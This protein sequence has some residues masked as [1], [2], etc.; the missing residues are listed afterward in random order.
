M[1]TERVAV[2]GAR[3]ETR[4]SQE[5][6]GLRVGVADNTRDGTAGTVSKTRVGHEQC[7]MLTM[8]L[9]KVCTR[10]ETRSG[11]ERRGCLSGRRV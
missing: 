8:F 2:T 11:Q 1:R 9:A 5:R 4:T 6:C 10:G 3:S 7:A